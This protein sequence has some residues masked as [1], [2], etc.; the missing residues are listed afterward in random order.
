LLVPLLVHEL[1]HSLA[2]KIKK[3]PASLPYLL[4]APPLQ[5]GFLGTFGAVINMR[6][7]PATLKDLAFIA[8]AGPVSGFLVALPI[9]YLGIAQSAV[10]RAEEVTSGIEIPIVP[11]IF[12]V[13][14]STK[15]EVPNGFVVV[16]SPLAFATMIVFF[17]T[18]LNLI[19]VGMLD[20][21]HVVRV[22]L[23]ER[24]HKYVGLFIIALVALTVP[25]VPILSIYLLVLILIYTLSRG[26]HPGSSYNLEIRSHTMRVAIALVYVLLLVLTFPIPIL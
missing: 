15:L 26:R 19:P 6:W 25:L 1:G 12:L 24:L 22:L 18:F 17:V 20:G 10:V 13:L 8:L 3:V 5:L 21:G 9:A 16:L 4:P 2:M 23:G 7:L 14:L 11:L